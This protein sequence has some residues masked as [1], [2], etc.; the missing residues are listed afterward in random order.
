MARAA[1]LLHDIGKCSAEF[2]A[3]IREPSSAR[4][5]DHSSAGAQEAHRAY[6]RPVGRILG[7]IVA[8]HHAGLADGEEL[9]R[10]LGKSLSNYG[11]WQA[12]IGMLPLPALSALAPTRRL[13][14]SDFGGFTA[15]FLIRMLFSSLVDADR[16]ET[17][18]FYGVAARVEATPLSVLRDRLQGF[19]G[20]MASDARSAAATG[21]QRRLNTLRS[22]ILDAAVTKAALAPGLFTLTVPTGGGKTLASLSFALEHAVRHGLHRVVYVIPFTSIIDQTTPVFRAALGAAPDA[23]NETDIVEHHASFDWDAA[24]GKSQAAG[25]A[26]GGTTPAEQ[27]QRATE[28]WDAPI[29]VTTAVQFFESL[30]ARGASACRKLHNL[31]GAVIV[32]DEA[33]T[34]PIR[35]L[36]PCLAAIDELARNYGASIVICTATQPAWRKGDGTLVEKRGSPAQRNFGLDVPPERELAPDPKRL[37]MELKRVEVEYRPAP[38]S[39][40][41]I[42]ERFAEAPQMLCIVNSRRHAKALF[43]AIVNL[44]GAIHLSTWMCPRHRRLVLEQARAALKAGEPTRIVSTSL[45]EAGVDID[46]PEVWRAATGVDSLLQAAG[47]CNR[48]FRQAAGRLVIFVPGEDRAPHDLKQSWEAGRAVLRRHPDPQT[49]EAIQAYFRELYVNAGDKALDASKLGGEIWPILGAISERADTLDF[50]FASIAQAFKVVEETMTPVIVPWSSGPQDSAAKDLL[51][52]IAAM[53]KPLRGDL[54][55]LQQYTVSVPE[56]RRNAWLAAGVLRPVHP[57]FGEAMLRLED[58]ALYDPRSGLRVDEPEH[59]SPESNVM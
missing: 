49:L 14:Q 13:F 42:A 36:K 53:D 8:G 20:A 22:E 57:E 30:F 15:V 34:L 55:R 40:A 56:T 50:P 51:A 23:P 48:E 12:E 25:E 58:L 17:S 1:G 33:Q 5:P 32:L 47:R 18:Q 39:D 45:I 43:D 37:F 31:A 59:R 29:I 38:I 2:Q 54:R 52:R 21:T 46:L 44:P 19:M 41:P 26:G 16:L 24:L 7:Y 6:G 35:I 11:G 10:R 28:N 27:L 9:A 3:Y 4:G